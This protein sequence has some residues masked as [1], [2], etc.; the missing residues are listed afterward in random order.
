MSFTDVL[1]EEI[2]E[3][4]SFSRMDLAPYRA[5]MDNLKIGKQATIVVPTG[6]LDDK[7]KGKEAKVH[8]R[9]FRAVATERNI[10]LRVGHNNMPDNKTRLKLTVDKKRE[11]SPEAIKKREASLAARRA[12]KEAAEKATAPTPAAPAAPAAKAAA[13]VAKASAS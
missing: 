6:E 9:G 1:Y 11:F 7:G 5:V 12:E 4:E 3:G 10:G 13:P 8:E 2:P